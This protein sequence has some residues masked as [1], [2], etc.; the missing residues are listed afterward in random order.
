MAGE[1]TG[2]GSNDAQATAR[3][4]DSINETPNDGKKK[5]KGGAKVK[6]GCLTCKYVIQLELQTM[7]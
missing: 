7:S 2:N 5:R 1:A 4:S 6:S 3:K